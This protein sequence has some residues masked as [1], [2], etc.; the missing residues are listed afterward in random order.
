VPETGHGERVPD[1]RGPF[2]VTLNRTHKRCTPVRLFGETVPK[3]EI[4]SVQARE[5]LEKTREKRGKVGEDEK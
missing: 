2:T 4:A 1:Y 5:R 3:G